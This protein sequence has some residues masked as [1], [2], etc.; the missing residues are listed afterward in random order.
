MAVQ[1][2][3]INSRRSY[4]NVAAGT[5]VVKSLLE[6]K[7]HTSADKKASVDTNTFRPAQQGRRI[8]SHP[9]MSQC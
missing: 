8:N 7:L 2:A 5:G 3:R 1:S 4:G 6:K 9:L